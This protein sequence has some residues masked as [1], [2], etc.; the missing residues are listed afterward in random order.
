[1]PVDTLTVRI[2]QRF[3]RVDQ[4]SKW[5]RADTSTS[6]VCSTSSWDSLAHET[7]TMK[8]SQPAETAGML[9][10]DAAGAAAPRWCTSRG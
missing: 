7:A 10:H 1:M 3:Q 9:S 4:T 6:F 5:A 8:W 2:Q